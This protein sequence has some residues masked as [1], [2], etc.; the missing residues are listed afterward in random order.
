MR[1]RG[2]ATW[3]GWIGRL[4]RSCWRHRG[5]T[6]GVVLASVAA[7]GLTAAF[8]LVMQLGVDEA[9]AG[10]TDHLG[11]LV[12]GMLV[13]ALIGFGGSF[14][15]Q[16]LGGT[17]ALGV[18]H[19]LRT[20][21]FRSL[22]R[23]DGGSQDALRTGRVVA[24]ANTDLQ[25][26]QGLLSMA[27]PALGSV[28]LILAS[29][30]AM[31]WLS[32]VLSLVA[33]AMVPAFGVVTFR[34]SRRLYPATWVVEQRTARIA[35]HVE[36]TVTG[37]RVVKGF[38]Q[39]QREADRLRD[40]ARQLFAARMRVAR[41]QATP[42][43]TLGILPSVGQVVV[44]VLGGWLAVRGQVSLGGLLAFVNY[45][46][47]LTA[48]S[49]VLSNLV[50]S[51]QLV[52]PAANRVY[53]LIDARPDVDDPPHAI[54]LPTGPLGVRLDDVRFGY[55]Q[56]EPV[57]DGLSLHVR[58]GETLAIVGPAGAGKSTISLLLPRFYQVGEGTIGI[59]PEG[60]E[61]D[62][63]RVRLR[64]LR[65]TVGVV[66]QEAF[67]FS[68]SVADN[69]AYG[70]PDA[71]EEQIRAAAVAAGA[72]EFISALPDGY[73]TR[74]GER[75]LTLSGGQRQRI[76]LARTLLSDPRVLVLDDATSAVD[77]ATEAAIHATLSRVTA[78][79]TTLLIAHRQPTLALADRVAVLDRGRVVDI[80]TVAELTARCPLFVKLFP[81]AGDPAGAGHPAVPIGGLEGL[82]PPERLMSADEEAA[83]DPR[84]RDQIRRLPPATDEPA[85]G[86]DT[87]PAHRR[88]GLGNVLRPV[89]RVL[90]LA[91]A[92][93][94]G[95]ALAVTAVPML[96]RF[97]MDSG[98][99]ARSMAVVLAMAGLALLVIAG[100]WVV[101]RALPLVTTRGGESAMFALRMRSYVHLQRLSL[102]YYEHELGGRIMTRMTTDVAAL[103]M[104]VESGLTI[105][106]VSVATIA[107][108][109]VAMVATDL[110]LA[111]AGLTVLPVLAVATVVFR[112][113]SLVAYTRSREQIG[114]VNADLQ[115]NIAGL[116]TAQAGAGEEIAE[117]RFSGLS[118]D[119]RRTRVLA[120]RYIALYFPFVTLLAETATAIVLGV[121]AH[122]VA[123]GTMTVGVLIV[124]M[125]YLSL[126]LA[127]IQ[128]LSV[129]FDGYQQARVGVDRIGELLTTPVSVR[130]P[131]RPVPM[132]PRLRG[133]VTL[134]SLG[135]RYA[136]AGEPA[137]SQVSLWVRPGERIALVGATGAGKS[138]L[139]KLLARYYDATEGRLLV[140]GVD[141]RSYAIEDYRRQLGVV[142]QEAHLFV[143]T[144]ADNVRYGR[145]E[146]SDAQVEDAVRAVGALHVVAGLPGGFRFRVG[147]RGQGLSAGQRQLIALA[148]AE[149]VDPAVLLFDEPTGAL[150]PTTEAMVLAASDRVS[151]SRTTFV[152]AHR[153]A[154]AALADRIVVL[155]RGRVVEVG[156][157]AELLATG[158]HY[159]RLW[160]H[161]TRH[162]AAG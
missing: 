111:L 84:L 162:A 131:R 43:A 46:V 1:A 11:W 115:E 33:L 28:V 149:L 40:L 36:E 145:P 112:R 27:P 58:P 141:I 30:A 78:D 134:H 119:Y 42:S 93:V 48:P 73:R 34:A 51:S 101:L 20:E 52:R 116:R 35:Q 60:A 25:M 142:P 86:E 21:V 124:F 100:N 81:A 130:T 61:V 12:A 59:G 16:L 57:L 135:Y 89:R 117:R 72:D 99:G 66:F 18:Q 160:Q 148:R 136:P 49:G 17:L 53:D 56:D 158:G 50:I 144:V 113:C 55:T 137:L 68:C 69:I 90:L 31:L 104:F 13:A 129:V 54:E 63:R 153:L 97:G 91:A 45:T 159:D 6:V 82:W 105:A 155:E 4:V 2:L 139:M 9:V 19:D 67:L 71:T 26:V 83:D 121:G 133:E 39:E 15:R 24:R 146:A 41:M 122:R 98:V 132:P 76:A 106:V 147:E 109:T 138:T 32:P 102:D 126:F 120:Q 77:A 88:F 29:V 38:G 37:V 75:G 157:H 107:V 140:D 64:S 47:T 23:L 70:H 79:R 87:S 8:P 74:V 3:G 156:T 92:L 161:Q 94:L 14:A 151:R 128:Q 108:M 150:D 80:G 62:I 110:T 44:L 152:V 114:E 125:L 154:T 7:T 118:D 95:D 123:A 143:G 127:P 22:Q 10:H 103:S 65:R 5:L 96:I 85:I